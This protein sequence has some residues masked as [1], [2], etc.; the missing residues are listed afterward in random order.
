MK[1]IIVATDF[2]PIAL[3]AINY[4]VAMAKKINAQ[5]HLLHVCPSPP[6]VFGD[7]VET[8]TVKDVIE[9]S[10]SQMTALKNRLMGQEKDTIPIKTKVVLGDFFDELEDLCTKEKPYV[11]I[12]GCQGKT[13]LE[14]VFLGSHALNTM[15]NLNWPVLIVPPL[16]VFT[17]IKR[18]GLA[19]DFSKPI[20]ALPIAD[21]KNILEDFNAELHIINVGKKGHYDSDIVFESVRLDDILKPFEPKHHFIDNNDIDDGIIEFIEDEKIDILIIL[22][23]RHSLMERLVYKSST[24]ILSLHTRVPLLS[25]H[26]LNLD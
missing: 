20:D 3:N 14:R 6:I 2:S 15:R 13:A 22:P 4:A 16:A 21:V 12:M 23:K 8:V 5:L 9:N 18:I 24:K 7:T 11:V 17:D 25:L 10:E 26:Q 19:C 1:T